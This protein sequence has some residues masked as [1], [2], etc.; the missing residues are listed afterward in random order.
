MRAVLDLV[1]S[2]Q[3]FNAADVVEHL[4]RADTH[5]NRESVL[6]AMRRL[7]AAGRIQLDRD[8]RGYI[9]SV[10]SVATTQGDERAWIK[11]GVRVAFSTYTS[12]GRKPPS[13]HLMWKT[14]HREYYL[15]PGK[16]LSKVYGSE[17]EWN[18]RTDQG[19]ERVVREWR[20]HPHKDRPL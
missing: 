7:E 6:R 17:D 8:S 14:G 2:G 11:P 12:T 1:E 19:D 9:E 5:S 20:L 16:V 4:G 10:L 3:P 15:I 18:I 13:S